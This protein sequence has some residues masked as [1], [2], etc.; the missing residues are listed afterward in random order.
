MTDTPTRTRTR[1]YARQVLNQVIYGAIFLEVLLLPFLES[2]L[3]I[4]LAPPSQAE[5]QTDVKLSSK[6][7]SRRS[8]IAFLQFFEAVAAAGAPFHV[9]PTFKVAK[10]AFLN[11]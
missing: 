8:P 4:K 1:T 6:R 2:W 3:H 10:V 7:T 5:L 11:D 9:T